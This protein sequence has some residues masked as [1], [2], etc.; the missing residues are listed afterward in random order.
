[1]P[2]CLHCAINE[3]IDDYFEEHGE[4][5]EGTLVLDDA[6]ILDALSD[7]LAEILAIEPEE[8][9]R[10]EVCLEPARLGR[11]ALAATDL[12]AVR[13]EHDHV[14]RAERVAIPAVL[15]QLE[16]PERRDGAGRVVLV[17]S[18]RSLDAGDE[19]APARPEAVGEVGVAA[20]LVRDVAEHGDWTGDPGDERGSLL[21]PVRVAR[22][23]VPDGE[24][25]AGRRCS[26]GACV[27]C[28]SERAGESERRQ[29]RPQRH[30]RAALRR[31]GSRSAP[32]PF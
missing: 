31:S 18:E 1:M 5:H 22:G 15:R 24:Q 17:V 28:E 8:E 21:V 3:T 29:A 10:R 11:V 14:P 20:V 6:I 23:D 30:R 25:R 4:R 7:V 16:D 2:L 9:V 12:A 26:C 32:L 19:L 13:V 27:T